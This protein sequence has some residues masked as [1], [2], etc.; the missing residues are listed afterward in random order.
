[1]TDKP[2]AAHRVRSRG[3]Y[4]AEPKRR[5]P[6]PTRNHGPVSQNVAPNIGAPVSPI[7]GSGCLIGVQLLATKFGQ[8]YL[9]VCCSGSL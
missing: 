8:A 6:T 3:N 7:A 5:I 4:E 9:P 1:M 2:I